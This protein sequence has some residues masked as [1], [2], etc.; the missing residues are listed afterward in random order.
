MVAL[1]AL[2]ADTTALVQ[3]GTLGGPAAIAAGAAINS[4]YD[5]V[6]GKII[7]PPGYAFGICTTATGTTHVMQSTLY[8]IE[9][10]V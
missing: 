10:L 7:V 5:N 8:W 1:T 9:T 6:D 4:V 3:V 2:D